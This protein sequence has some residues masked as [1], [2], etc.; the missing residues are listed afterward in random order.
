MV[1]IHKN[2]VSN[3]NNDLIAVMPVKMILIIEMGVNYL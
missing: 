2:L 3:S 1:K